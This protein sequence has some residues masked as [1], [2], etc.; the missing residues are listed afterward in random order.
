[1][2]AAGGLDKLVTYYV[3]K[4]LSRR[5]LV[6]QAQEEFNFTIDEMLKDGRLVTG[7]MHGA[8]DWLVVTEFMPRTA[9]QL[10]EKPNG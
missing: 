2:F 5:A 6:K 9:A 3:D 8:T 7:E 1:M 4:G 10:K